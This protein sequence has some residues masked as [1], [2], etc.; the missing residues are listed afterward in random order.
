MTEQD[1]AGLGPAFS[2]Y[3]SSYR[4]CFGQARTAAH[5]DTACRGV[6]TDLLR[7]S[8]EPIALPSG[9]A[10]R[11]LQEFLVT[12]KWDQEL[13][14]GAWPTSGPRSRTRSGRSG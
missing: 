4:P 7:K 8:V 6:L 12:S 14:R 9:T 2:R 1:I 10:V 13:A 11:T 3:R 5:V